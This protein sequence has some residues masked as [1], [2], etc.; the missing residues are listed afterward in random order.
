[1][2]QGPFPKDRGPMNPVKPS[3]HGSPPQATDP[4]SD[5]GAPNRPPWIVRYGPNSSTTDTPVSRVATPG[6]ASSTGA[7]MV[8]YLAS[9]TAGPAHEVRM[10]KAGKWEHDSPSFTHANIEV[11]NTGPSQNFKQTKLTRAGK[12]TGQ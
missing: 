11:A 9:T 4:S 8:R 6:R 10:D 5:F 1:M 7:D 3:G 12:K 2:K